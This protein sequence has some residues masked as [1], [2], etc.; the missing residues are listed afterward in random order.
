MFSGQVFDARADEDPYQEGHLGL[1]A[2]GQNST[3]SDTG[4]PDNIECLALDGGGVRVRLDQWKSHTQF[5]HLNQPRADGVFDADPVSVGNSS[6]FKG[7]AKR[8][9]M[10]EVAGS[11]GQNLFRTFEGANGGY[12]KA[13]N[14]VAIPWPTGAR[15]KGTLT[16]TGGLSPGDQVEVGGKTY[17]FQNV[18]TDVDGNVAMGTFAW[19]SLANL[20]SAINTVPDQAGIGYA[21]STTWQPHVDASHHEDGLTLEV[22]ARRTGVIGNAITTSDPVDGGVVMAWSAA[23]LVGGLEGEAL[24]LRGYPFNLQV[25]PT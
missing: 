24:P 6:F 19:D 9:I 5:T 4:T 2:S 20:M 1:S 11:V 8:E 3:A 23:T 7:W 12:F 18:L 25:I 10:P 16:L 14:R 21:A 15:A 17:T 22:R 13:G